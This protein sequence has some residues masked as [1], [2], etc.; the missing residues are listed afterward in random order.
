MKHKFS[1]V[2]IAYNNPNEITSTLESI[3]KLDYPK[4]LFDVIIV[5]DGSSIKLED[6]IKTPLNYNHKFH[7]IDRTI[8]SS[9]SNARNI[10]STYARN[11]WILFI[12]GDQYLNPHILS[13]YNTYINTN[14]NS[15]IAL[16]T[17]IDLSDWQSQLLLDTNDIDK[18]NKLIRNQTDTRIFIKQSLKEKFI[19]T[20]GI[21]TLFWSHNFII[22]NDLFNEVGKFDDSFI[23]WGFEDVELGYR[24]TKAGYKYDIIENNVYHFHEENKMNSEKHY[25]WIK[26]ME[27]FYKKHDD[28]NIMCQWFFYESLS[29][30]NN[31]KKPTPQEMHDIFFRYSSKIEF[32]DTMKS[33]FI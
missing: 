5:D 24:L 13:I 18:I 23:H 2:I 6:S 26:N 30:Y 7:Y 10:G 16:G 25:H 19:T 9:R 3:N 14:K 32:M 33:K 8:N 12:D 22:H 31:F 29:I 1:V 15:N 21:W 11:E 17:R 28:I 27:K 4:D 20:P